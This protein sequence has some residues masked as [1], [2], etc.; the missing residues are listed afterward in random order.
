MTLPFSPAS[1][2]DEDLIREL[3][4]CAYAPG[5]RFGGGQV[6]RAQARALDAGFLMPCQGRAGFLAI[7]ALGRARLARDVT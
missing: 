2:P 1:S 6:G 4:Y 7:T 5:G 3:H